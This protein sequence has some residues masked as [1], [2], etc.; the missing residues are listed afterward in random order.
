MESSF[1]LHDH[2]QQQRRALSEETVSYAIYFP[3]ATIESAGSEAEPDTKT[4]T[5][6]EQTNA[7]AHYL[8]D[9]IHIAKTFIY[10]IVTDLTK[11]YIWHKDAF[12]LH[13]ETKKDTCKVSYPQMIQDN[14]GEFLLI[15]AAEHI[16]SWLDPENSDNRV[17]I[18]NGDL[19]IIPIAVTADE[20]KIY[21]PTLGTKSESPKLQDALEIIWT[22][23]SSLAGKDW[24]SS[25]SRAPT[26]VI[27]TLASPAIQRAAFGPLSSPLSSSSL[28]LS[29]DKD[30]VARKIQEQK[31]YARCQIPLDVAR[32]LK[33]RPEL[34]TRACEAFYT[35]D[36]LGM[37]AC[38]R[39]AK[40]LPRKSSKTASSDKDD[41]GSELGHGVVKL[42]KNSTLFVTTSVCFTKTCYAQ[43]MGQQF[44]PPKIWDGIVPPISVEDAN[45]PQ[46]LKEA[47]LGMKL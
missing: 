2:I 6:Q 3:K 41:L 32:V 10:S 13:V 46:K 14:D 47:E 4:Q 25:K 12:S 27:P 31:H 38:S 35:R 44:H 16:P 28:N 34:V 15:E 8:L 17:F 24:N 40:F 37:A 18:H 29:A 26:V 9:S 39:M 5:D 23:S 20:K 36:A 11:D 1:P 45:D 22:S 42:G 30:F 19:H 43:L 7:A 21:P 33:I